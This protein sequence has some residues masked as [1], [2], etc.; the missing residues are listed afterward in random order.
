[1]FQPLKAMAVVVALGAITVAQDQSSP[2]PPP[3]SSDIAVVVNLKNPA[4]HLSLSDLRKMFAGETRRWPGGLPV[5][6]IIR[7]PEARER[8]TVLHLL[9]LSEPEFN[10]YWISQVRRNEADDPVAV[11]SNGM[12]KEAV[13]AFPGAIALMAAEDVRPGMKLLKIDD[14]LPREEG[15]PLH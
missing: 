8:E 11:F 12:Q 10:H 5:K 3:P 14:K 2:N 7:A 6:L 9:K 1:M 15:Y 4:T 13:M